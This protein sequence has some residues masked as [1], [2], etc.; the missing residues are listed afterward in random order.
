MVYNLIVNFVI[1]L[2][3]KV[4]IDFKVKLHVVRAIY[5]YRISLLKFKF[6]QAFKL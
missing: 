3:L 5:M 1:C 4:L 6:T 2:F